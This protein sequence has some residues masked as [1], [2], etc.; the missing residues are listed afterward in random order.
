MTVSTRTRF[1]V[2]KRDRFTCH[3]CGRTP[4]T[5]LLELDHVLPRVAGGTDDRENLI[6]AC[7]D[8]NRGKAGNLLEEGAAPV[9]SRD[10]VAELA[11]RVKQAQAY[12]EIVQALR[13]AETDQVQ[14][15]I[16]AWAVAF[17]AATEA[18]ADGNYWVLPGGGQFPRRR[19]IKTILARLP[20]H[21]VL[22]S[23]EVTAAWSEDSTE[24]ACRYFYGVCWK[25]IRAEGD[26]AVTSPPETDDHSD[27]TRQSWVDYGRMQAVQ[28]IADLEAQLADREAEVAALKITVRR[29][30]EEAGR[31]G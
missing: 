15:V 11:E 12:A 16:D 28:E 18:R 19:S 10:V 17:E 30:R 5:V 21:R 13:A 26:A 6:T 24:R 20:L 2:F 3:Y 4:P 27:E 25:R 23:V 14:Q 7:Q 8:C 1:E 31:G 29:L 9:V 22:E